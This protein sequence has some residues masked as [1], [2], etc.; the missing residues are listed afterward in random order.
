[1]MPRRTTGKRVSFVTVPTE[2][3]RFFLSDGTFILFAIDI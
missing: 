2:K 3:S 1:M